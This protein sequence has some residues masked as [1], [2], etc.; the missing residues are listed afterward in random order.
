MYIPCFLIHSFDKQLICHYLTPA[1]MA[2]NKTK[3][4]KK[5]NKYWEDVEK[6]NPGT[7]LVGMQI[8]ETTMKKI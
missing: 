5:D 2:I 7:L 3:Q 6:E 4:K 8:G 1:G